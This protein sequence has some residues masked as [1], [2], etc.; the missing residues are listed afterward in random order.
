MLPSARLVAATTSRNCKPSKV[1]DAAEFAKLGLAKQ[2]L[3]LLVHSGSRGLGET[4]LRDHV[5]EHRANGVS[6][7]SVAAEEYLRGHDFAVRWAKAN[8]ELIAHRFAATL[9]AVTECLWDGCHNNI[10][11][12]EVGSARCADRTSQ[13][14]V[15]YQ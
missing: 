11:P 14:D 15:P 7:D 8:R 2:Q 1:L 10:T 4:I 3:V 6:A 13:R 9:G 5:A 12:V